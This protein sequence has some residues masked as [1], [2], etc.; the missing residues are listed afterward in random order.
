[1]QIFIYYD[2]I[3]GRKWR[4]NNAAKLMKHGILIFRLS[5]CPDPEVCDPLVIMTDEGLLPPACLFWHDNVK[6]YVDLLGHKLISD[7]V[8]QHVI[9]G[10]ELQTSELVGFGEDES[11]KFTG[12]ILS[13]YGQLEFSFTNDDNETLTVNWE[14]E[15]VLML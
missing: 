4:S 3:A 13:E 10:S 9:K 14:I 8:V 7:V 6:R 15:P 1:L 12:V 5:Q 2:V 11:Y